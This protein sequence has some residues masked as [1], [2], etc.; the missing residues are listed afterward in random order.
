MAA[1]L[2]QPAVPAAAYD[3]AYY[4]EWCAGSDE[5]VAS[6]G[7]ETAGIY[8]GFLARAGM[9]AGEVV[10]DIGTG[11]GELLAVAVELGAAHAYGVEYSPD[12]VRMAGTTLERHGVGAKAEVLLADAR[13]VPLGDGIADL[14]CMVDVAEHLTPDELLGAL[15]EARRLLK[16]GGRVVI[17]TMPNRLIY[18][19]TYRVLRSTLGLCRWPKDPRNHLE[20]TMHVNEQTARSLRRSLTA[21]GFT[22]DVELGAWVYT[23]FL[24]GDRG[25]RV[26]HLLAKLGP[27][28]QLGLGDLW[29][30]GTRP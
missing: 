3:E 15:R 12:A 7:S 25:R 29:A 26:Y 13:R 30:V 20:R 24:P 11:R 10:V 6:G 5:W 17:H 22:A 14:V 28:A 2:P 27:L 9:R 21:A 18:S 8:P 4:R 19:V 16:P 1:P 23:D